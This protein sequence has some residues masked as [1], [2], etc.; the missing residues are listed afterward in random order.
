MIWQSRYTCSQ[1]ASSVG[2]ER[3]LA[4]GCPPNSAFKKQSNKPSRHPTA[5]PQTDYSRRLSAKLALG[6]RL[7]SEGSIRRNGAVAQLAKFTGASAQKGR[8]VPSKSWGARFT[9]Y[10]YAKSRK[11]RAPLRKNILCCRR[12]VARSDLKY[13][14]ETI[15]NGVGTRTTDTA[16]RKSCNCV[17]TYIETLSFPREKNV[18][19]KRISIAYQ[20]FHYLA[21]K[22]TPLRSTGRRLC[23][24]K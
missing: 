21:R 6:S 18:F 9:P 5:K 13:G 22:S 17:T 8:S 20:T 7:C 2:S 3:V 11:C 14:V 1:P 24:K 12:N 23:T 16:M 4:V 15:C 10:S 19:S